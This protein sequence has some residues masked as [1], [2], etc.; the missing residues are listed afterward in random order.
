MKS[1]QY[2]FDSLDSSSSSRYKYTFNGSKDIEVNHG[3]P[4]FNTSPSRNYFSKSKRNEESNNNSSSKEVI[5]SVP[6]PFLSELASSKDF[7]KDRK[8]KSELMRD[9]RRPNYELKENI[10]DSLNFDS[11]TENNEINDASNMTVFESFNQE[12]KINLPKG[13]RKELFPTKL[14]SHECNRYKATPEFQKYQTRTSSQKVIH[15]F[16]KDKSSENVSFFKKNSQKNKE[17]ELNGEK[18]KE[19]F[20]Y[21]DLPLQYTRK[22]SDSF[23]KDASETMDENVGM[24]NEVSFDFNHKFYNN[25]LKNK[26][27]NQKYAQNCNKKD[28][29]KSYDK[30]TLDSERLKSPILSINFRDNNL[31][32]NTSNETT[33][34][35]FSSMENTDPN[36]KCNPF[37]VFNME[38]ISSHCLSPV[39]KEKIINLIQNNIN[40]VKVK[41]KKKKEKKK[42]SI[43][44]DSILFKF[45]F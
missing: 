43:L 38:L 32:S 26:E 2:L 37:Y 29:N 28:V 22:R 12:T 7:M 17:N 27:N 35:C 18:K 34:A 10:L 44:F 36:R 40:D 8:I 23:Y 14:P 15:P 31:K 4:I 24:H 45:I 41:L 3:S 39:D 1:S 19:L 5:I 6:P 33:T 9:V 11:L 42:L 16:F 30:Q 13:E 21:F 25:F 20:K